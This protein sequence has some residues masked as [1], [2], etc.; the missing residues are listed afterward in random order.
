MIKSSRLY[1]K[2][3]QSGHVVSGGRARDHIVSFFVWRLAV[4]QLLL[5]FIIIGMDCVV[6][7]SNRGLLVEQ[8]LM[9]MLWRP[10]TLYYLLNV[11]MRSELV[12]IDIEDR[13]VQENDDGSCLP[14]LSIRVLAFLVV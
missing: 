6:Y 8:F 5:D 11:V 12:D 3:A 14:F 1:G 4:D 13:G 9:L 7:A 10:I 2:V